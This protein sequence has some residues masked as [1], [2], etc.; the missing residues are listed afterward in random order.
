MTIPSPTEVVRAW[1][2]AVNARNE[3]RLLA[4]SDPEIEIVG[5]RGSV[6]GHAVLTDWL[7]RAGLRFET[8]RRFARGAEVV[9]EQ[10]GRWHDLDTG[11]V[12]SEVPIASHYRVEGERVVYVARYDELS[13]ALGRAGLEE[14]QGVG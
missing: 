13:T 3:T 12:V 5:P 7:G 9:H 2:E 6:R 4:L 1:E 8:R 10:V 14:G 11:A